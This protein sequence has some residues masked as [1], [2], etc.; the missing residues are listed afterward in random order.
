M[1]WYG[2]ALVPVQAQVLLIDQAETLVRQKRLPEA[3]EA[4]EQV[5]RHA[6]TE[7]DP[8]AW[9]TRGYIYKELFLTAPDS[10]QRDHFRQTA[11]ASLDIG[12]QLDRNGQYNSRLHELRDYIH[13]TLYNESVDAF[14]QQ[15]Y[16]QAKDGFTKFLGLRQSLPHDELYA[17]ALY[18]LGWSE[19]LLG[20]R[21]HA[22]THYQEALAAGH[23]N[24][25]LF[26][27]L[28]ILLEDAGKRSEAQR[29]VEAGL[30]LFPDAPNLRVARINFLLDDAEYAGAQAEVDSLLQLE[31]NN[32]E[33]LLVA[34]T[35]YG[36]L[37]EADT[38][39][40]EQWYTKRKRIYE[41]ALSVDPVDFT[42]NYNLGIVLYNRAVD[43]ITG[44]SYDLE[45][46]EL[47]KILGQTTALF[48][49]ALPY[50]EKA[51]HLQ[52]DNRN[53]LR[54]LEGIYYC[55]NEKDKSKAI[56]NRLEALE[57]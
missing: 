25:Y 6:S 17:E 35:V 7:G 10:A 54:A 36:K 12:L 9:Y 16:A 29:L 24:P 51:N 13:V 8:R 55:L 47:Y 50:I 4:I 14:N 32:A 46:E 56:R 30:R 28:A 2:G 3:Q 5:I 40:W 33:I 31:P 18:Q 45:L 48:K 22:L 57:R 11:L 38:L 49:E 19:S 15:E 27:D 43:L 42:A 41:R 34:G 1:L 20:D 26:E 44:Q 21:Q 52:P 39:R 37:Q 53:T 23:Q